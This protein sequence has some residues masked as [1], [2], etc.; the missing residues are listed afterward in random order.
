MFMADSLIRGGA[1]YAG[2]LP[3]DDPRASP[4]YGHFEGLPPMLVFAST[5][6]VL[7]D[8]SVRLA[9]KARAA[10]VSVDL[11]VEKGL[12]HVWPLFKPL[13]PESARAINKTAA[14]IR[15]R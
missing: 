9:E 8:D 12:V 13:M 10:G 1:R 6:E 5:D 3:L 2:D 15:G 14:F 4:L 7:R 11:V